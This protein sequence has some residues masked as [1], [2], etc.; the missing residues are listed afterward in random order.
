PGLSIQFLFVGTG[1]C[2][3]ASLTLRDS[4]SRESGLPPHVRDLH[5]LE[6]YGIFDTRCPCRAHT[7][8]IAYG[9]QVM[10][11]AFLHSSSFISGRKESAFKPPQAICLTLVA[12]I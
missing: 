2:S 9:G 10:I 12:S 1:V 8:H 7:L 3:L 5:H 11:Y 4:R 6:Y